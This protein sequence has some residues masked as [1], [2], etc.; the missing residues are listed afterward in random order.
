MA[1]WTE[2]SGGAR[3]GL[4]ALGV[5]GVAIVGALSWRANQP[6]AIEADVA[7]NAASGSATG[8]AAPV[9]EPSEA[10][11]TP[12]PVDS[13]SEA[14]A[15]AIALPIAPSFDNWRVEGDGSAVVS[16]RAESG[17]LITVLVDGAVVADAR[18]SAS[19]A[20]ALLFT[21]PANDQPSV[22]TL[23]A[24]LADGSKL[25][26][27]QTI[28]LGPIA[29]PTLADVASANT[30]VAPA[31][32][33]VAL[34]VTEDSV[35]VVQTAPEAAPEQVAEP[36]TAETGTAE[37]TTEP[38]AEADVAAS[39]IQQGAVAGVV[40]DAISYNAAGDVILSGKGQGGQFVR[41]YLDNTLTASTSITPGGTWQ[42]TLVDTA[43]GIYTLRADQVDAV[44]KVS[45]RFETPFQRETR[46]ALAALAAPQSAPTPGTT[47]A[48]A[49][50]EPA[51]TSEPAASTGSLS[52]SDA[53]ADVG[54]VETVATPIAQAELPAPATPEPATPEIVTPEPAAPAQATA[55]PSA[56]P[57]ETPVIAQAQA[58]ASAQ[59][60]A[61]AAATTTVLEATS[62]PALTDA[63][64]QTA[65]APAA[66]AP[67]V[68][69]EVASPDQPALQSAA[70]APVAD[71][72]T[73]GTAE[74]TPAA[75]STPAGIA[76]P[77]TEVAPSAVPATVS[78]TVQ[79]GYTLWGIARASL[80]DGVLY[81]QVF[82]ANKDKIKNPD[83]IY[84]G[85][86][87]TLPVQ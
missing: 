15:P 77:G 26:S 78:I 81:V 43:P 11:P 63:P 54:V 4:I 52:G 61:T 14:Q 33:P 56:P 36:A 70:A 2:M 27:L 62:E 29:G 42:M 17:A 13:P 37:A 30:E 34:V 3:A 19:G 79:P 85:Q 44:G 46:E 12:E 25:P 38:A 8:T 6:V 66:S 73:I 86:V 72:A 82:N 21:L 68:G 39:E 7:S 50:Q 59:E 83:L 74:G 69:A 55:E 87:F 57:A 71:L 45:A 16:G 35:T 24:T 1:S 10:V 80:G 28:A 22:M 9:P 20:F 64:Q 75:T 41:L 65:E 5:A 18:A 67:V 48:A 40:V 31:A 60:A 32:P 49:I 53:G 84:P 23:E 51:P 47:D 76:Q 58:G